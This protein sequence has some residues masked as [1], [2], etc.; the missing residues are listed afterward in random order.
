MQFEGS[1]KDGKVIISVPFTLPQ[2]KGFREE[3]ITLNA[4]VDTGATLTCLCGS[5]MNSKG[6]PVVFHR[7][8][9]NAQSDNYSVPFRIVVFNGSP[10]LCPDYKSCKYNTHHCLIGMD[11][12]KEMSIKEGQYTVVLHSKRVLQQ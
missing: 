4:L 12:I 5:L 6:V 11:L 8:M 7:E 10:L 9:Q 3:M 1:V 2:R